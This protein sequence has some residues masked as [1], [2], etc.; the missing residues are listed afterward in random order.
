MPRV[1]YDLDT[2]VPGALLL[3]DHDLPGTMSVTNAAEEVIAELAWQGLLA[4]RRVLYRD[5]DG[6]WDEL[7]HDGHHFNGFR[8]IHVRTRDEVLAVLSGGEEAVRG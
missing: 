4:G 2:S 8:S 6:I 7:L 5:T 3:V 1:S